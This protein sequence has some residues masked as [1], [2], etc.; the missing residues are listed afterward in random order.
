MILCHESMNG[1][2]PRPLAATLPTPHPSHR[3]PRS[4]SLSSRGT[5][6]GPLVTRE[7]MV[8]EALSYRIRYKLKHRVFVV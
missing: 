8:T 3:R 2:H 4:R 1:I 6:E 5:R 7:R